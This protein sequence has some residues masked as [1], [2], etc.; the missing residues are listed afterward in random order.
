MSRAA[1]QHSTATPT[2]ERVRLAFV[3]LNAACGWRRLTRTKRTPLVWSAHVPSDPEHKARHA[4]ACSRAYG[5][6]RLP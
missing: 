5:R 6:P 3:L 2:R 4:L 1:A